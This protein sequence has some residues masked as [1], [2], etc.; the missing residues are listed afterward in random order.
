MRDHVVQG[1]VGEE[2]EGLQPQPRAQGGEHLHERLEI[3]QCQQHHAGRRRRVGQAQGGLDDDAERALRG[4]GQVAQVV[5]AGVLDQATA[6][7]EQFAAPVHQL[8]PGHPL[9]GVAVAD[10]ADAAGIGGDVAADAAR[11]AR[12]EVHRVRESAFAGGVLHRLQR[13]PGLDGSVRSTVE[14]QHPVHPFQRRPVAVG[15]DRAT[16][17]GV[18]RRARWPRPTCPAHDGLHLRH[19]FITRPPG[20]RVSSAGSSR[21]RKAQVGGIGEQAQPG[22]PA[23]RVALEAGR[24]CRRARARACHRLGTAP[25]SV[26]RCGATKRAAIWHQCRSRPRLQ[27]RVPRCPSPRSQA[28]HPRGAVRGHQ[29]RAGGVP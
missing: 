27:S 11:A 9:A 12:G 4:H 16:D 21:G 2:L 5:A 26:E 13:R 6:D 28:G 14:T 7:V 10:H 1:A 24:S 20:A 17:A 23:A 3:R 8:Q 22:D 15:R 18:R 19:R 29:P 25:A